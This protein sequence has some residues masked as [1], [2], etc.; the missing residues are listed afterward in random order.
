MLVPVQLVAQHT[1]WERE[2]A[3]RIAVLGV[4]LHRD[5]DVR[6]Q[7]EHASIVA[8]PVVVERLHDEVATRGP[9]R[10]HVDAALDD[11]RRRARGRGR[12][13]QRDRE[14]R[15][16]NWLTGVGQQHDLRPQHLIAL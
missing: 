10:Q 7:V 6:A 4:A 9:G 1:G 13:M 12:V 16:S 8:A 2:V 3:E 11:D 15:A 5:A 14:L